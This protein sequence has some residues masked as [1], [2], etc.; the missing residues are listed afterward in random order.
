MKVRW[1][2]SSALLRA[3]ARMMSLCSVSVSDTGA[4]VPKSTATAEN[5]A[6]GV[7]T[8]ATTDSQGAYRFTNLPVGSYTLTA[9]VLGF[10]VGTLKGV[11]V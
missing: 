5:D 7:K 8:T 1:H 2:A 3:A 4:V 6:T 9:S 10:A 11:Q